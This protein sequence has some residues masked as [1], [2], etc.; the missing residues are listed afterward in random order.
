MNHTR[1]AGTYRERQAESFLHVRGLKTLTRNF[2]CRLGEIDLVMLDGPALVFAEV[3]YRRNCSHG[4]GAETVTMAKRRRLI[5]AA[6]VYLQRHPGQAH[7][8]CRFDV[9]SMSYM[10]GVLKCQWI[11]GA[12]TA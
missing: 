7:R 3:R 4:S 2:T 1:A 12:F 11:R 5:R 8:P 10:G 9:V 6:Q